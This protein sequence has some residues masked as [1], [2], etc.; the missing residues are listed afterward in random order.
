MFSLGLRLCSLMT[1]DPAAETG[2]TAQKL[3]SKKDAVLGQMQPFWVAWR[4]EDL[5]W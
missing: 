4:L 2:K 1:S 3:C 5:Q